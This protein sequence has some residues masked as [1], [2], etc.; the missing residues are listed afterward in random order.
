M[1]QES[2]L[3]VRHRLNLKDQRALLCIIIVAM[4][5][6]V[7]IINTKFI[8]ITNIIQIFQQISVL[9]ILTLAMTLLLVSGGIDLS[10]GNIMVLSAICMSSLITSGC[11]FVL[12]LLAGIGVALLCGALNG[13]IIAKSRCVPLIITLGT[14]QVF[15]GLSLTISE[16]RIMSFK[17]TLSGIGSTRIAGI[18]P[19]MLFF[20]IAMLVI[21]Y[22]LLNRTKFGRRIVA[23]GGNEKNAYLSGI[24]VDRYKILI[25]L[26]AGIYC[27]IA[28]IVFSARLDSVS[29]SAGSGYE[30]NALTAAIIGGCTFEG[31]RGTVSGSFLGCLFMGIITNAM[32]LLRVESYTQTI[33]TGIIIVVAVVLSNLSNLRERG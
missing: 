31:G 23:I 14:S 26:I 10:I 32:N 33:V 7:S 9:G 4:V 30:T 19:V 12:S 27:G 17:G 2:S 11:D 28:A 3:P 24:Q 5:V 29:A 22:I 6:L 16:G 21:S 8:D 25:Y 18:F 1:N 15:Y 20:L 13:A